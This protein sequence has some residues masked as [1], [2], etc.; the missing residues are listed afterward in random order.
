MQ[1]KLANIEKQ[2]AQI[3]KMLQRLLATSSSSAAEG[4]R[5][6]AVSMEDI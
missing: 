3:Q 2:Q 1:D 6:S 4:R 5:N